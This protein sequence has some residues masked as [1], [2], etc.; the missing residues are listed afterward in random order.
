[1]QKKIA[2]AIILGV[3]ILVVSIYA[4]YAVV[5]PVKY[6]DI[7]VT[8]ST[9]TNLSVPLVASLINV[10]SSYRKEAISSS[11][12]IGLMQIMPTT[13]EYVCSLNDIDFDENNM[14]QPEY[15]IKIGCLYLK[16]LFNKFEN[17]QTVLCSYNAGET[18]VRSWLNNTRY[19]LD[20]KTL[21]KIPFEET[22][23]YVNKINKNLKFYE[24]IYKN[25]D[26]S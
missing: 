15:N 17:T 23:N 8:E 13:F 10:E 21:Y 16:Y 18:L 22:F 26:F 24:R 5:Y 25:T 6:E 2:F 20:G 14:A 19:S 11:G 7:I 4:F 1:M 3:Y 12:A 9:N